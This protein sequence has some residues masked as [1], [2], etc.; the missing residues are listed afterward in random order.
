MLFLLVVLVVVTATLAVA[1]IWTAAA[2]ARAQIRWS[3]RA[4]RL[5]HLARLRRAGL[6]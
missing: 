2:R 5:Q 1:G 3:R 4:E 6:M